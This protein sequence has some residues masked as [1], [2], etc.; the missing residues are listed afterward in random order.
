MSSVTT[1]EVLAA[2]IFTGLTKPEHTIVSDD[3]TL[4]LGVISPQEDGSTLINGHVLLPIE[5]IDKALNQANPKV[6][7]SIASYHPIVQMELVKLIAESMFGGSSIALRSS[8]TQFNG[9][10]LQYPKSD[11]QIKPLGT[12]STIIQTKD[13]QTGKTVE[14]TIEQECFSIP[15]ELYSRGIVIPKKPNDDLLR[16]G[17]VFFPGNRVS[18]QE[19]LE[20]LKEY[21][22]YFNGAIVDEKNYRVIV[23]NSRIIGTSTR[24]DHQKNFG[25]PG[26]GFADGGRKRIT[27]EMAAVGKNGSTDVSTNSVM[28]GLLLGELDGEQ[29]YILGESDLKDRR[30]SDKHYGVVDSRVC[31]VFIDGYNMFL[32]PIHC[33]APL[34]DAGTESDTIRW[35]WE[36]FPE[37]RGMIN[38][39][40]RKM[41]LLAEGEQVNAENIDWIMSQVN[42]NLA[43]AL[44]IH[45]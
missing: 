5:W 14:V 33:D 23:P 11:I 38:A 19:D 40:L 24:P 26:N 42:I 32:V 8:L 15:V 39:A 28:R 13:P 6:Q 12:A 34:L 43:T 7:H 41:G 20:V 9:L 27:Q 21:A 45:R 10:F 22:N 16:I 37:M 25:L 29:V 44:K 30:L 35:E 17:R 18:E 3:L 2:E 1:G 36:A 31:E 4:E